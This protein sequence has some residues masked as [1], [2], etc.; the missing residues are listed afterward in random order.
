MSDS[1]KSE[2][3]FSSVV[4][5]DSTVD[6]SGVKRYFT[7][8]IKNEQQGSANVGLYLYSSVLK[9]G[10]LLGIKHLKLIRRFNVSK[11]RSASHSAQ[12]NL[13]SVMHFL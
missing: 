7:C 11:I 6:E 2:A 9:Q 4:S 12:C 13:P 1:P 10:F 8:S 3:W 5:L